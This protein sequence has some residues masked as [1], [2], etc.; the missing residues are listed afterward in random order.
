[1]RFNTLFIAAV[2]A[3]DGSLDA[4]EITVDPTGGGEF[5][6]V[7]AAVEA[8]QPGDEIVLSAGT[9]LVSESIWI[10]QSA[11]LTLRSTDG[12]EA[13]EIRAAEPA[14]P[15][16]E[17]TL[18]RLDDATALFRGLSFTNDRGRRGG[19][20]QI[21]GGSVV[22]V[23]DCRFVD[24]FARS[25]AGVF[26]L[27]AVTT[28]DPQ[29]EV[30]L[31]RCHFVGNS[32]PRESGGGLYLNDT[33]AR[34][35]DC[36][37]EGNTES[38]AFCTGDST[39]VAF[40]GCTFRNNSSRLGGAVYVASGAFPTFE[41]CLFEG[42][43]G[44]ESGGAIHNSN[45][46]MTL[47]DCVLRGNRTFGTGGAV[48]VGV[49]ARLH[50]QDVFIGCEFVR[51][52]ADRGGAVS[53]YYDFPLFVSCVFA[54]NFAQDAGGAMNADNFALP[55]LINCTVVQN[56]AGNAGGAFWCTERRGPASIETVAALLHDNIPESTCGPG[57]LDGPAFVQQGV[58]DVGRFVEV[59]IGDETVSVPDFVVETPD[60][61]LLPGSPAIDAAASTGAAA[62]DL[63]GRVRPCG[64]AHDLGAFESGDCEPS[65]VA[66]ELRLFQRGDTDGDGEYGINDAV[67]VLRS[68]F[69][70]S[71]T[72]DCLDAADIDDDGR[73]SIGD[74]VYLLRGLF[75]DE[76]TA[77]P[78]PRAGCGRDWT[79][80]ALGCESAACG[81]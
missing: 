37:F 29:P 68:L 72:L 69:E 74:P 13:T 66:A 34:V 17:L 77:P 21:G 22:T 42:N 8:A 36:V 81:D 64:D 15:G 16:D 71:A 11:D 59:R 61:R 20:L 2:L 46:T 76:N 12:A 58:F 33:P 3:T 45:C 24:S 54:G 39:D 27:G 60:Y 35:V 52:A 26:V 48:K 78:H 32:A 5:T 67:R 18:F 19:G 9:H 41:R 40:V 25:G 6:D 49:N 47:T 7:A 65:D 50:L 31:R 28:R 10:D 51:N 38:A 43:L 73:V 80:D 4:R 57:P 14:N 70:G 55:T 63:T 53:V 79:V 30:T 44:R 75:L 62:R 23:E 56:R 1:M